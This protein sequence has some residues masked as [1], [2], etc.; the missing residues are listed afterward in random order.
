MVEHPQPCGTAGQLQ[1]RLLATP[2]DIPCRPCPNPCVRWG[3]GCCFSATVAA[4]LAL[5]TSAATEPYRLSRCR[6]RLVADPSRLKV[7][8]LVPCSA[9][10]NTHNL[11]PCC[12]AHKKGKPGQT[13]A[14]RFEDRQ[15]SVL[16]TLRDAMVE[17]LDE[18]EPEAAGA[19]EMLDHAHRNSLAVRVMRVT[20]VVTVHRS[21][22]HATS[23]GEK[24]RLMTVM[25]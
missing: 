4:Q 3:A 23:L 25:R 13:V 12:R 2:Q 6:V 24:L 19:V 20:G 18:V 16:R 10:C 14:I 11:P 15:W 17:A 1:E 9:L 7:H 8:I 21:R 22:L 5:R